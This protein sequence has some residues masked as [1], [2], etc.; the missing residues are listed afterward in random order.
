MVE[1]WLKRLEPFVALDRDALTTLARHSRVVRIAAG[2]RIRNRQVLQRRIDAR[3]GDGGRADDRLC[4][5]IDGRVRL[6]VPADRSQR[7]VNAHDDVARRPLFARGGADASA[8][9]LEAC[10]VLWVDADPVAFLFD[11]ARLQLGISVRWLP[12]DS[13]PTGW[14]ERFVS[15]GL[16]TS[17]PALLARLFAALRRSAFED[18]QAVIEEGAPG[19][20]FFVVAQGRVEIRSRAG[21][22]TVLE[23]GAGFGE[24]AIFHGGP[25]NATARMLG[26]GRLMRLDATSFRTLLLPAAVHWRERDMIDPDIPIIDLDASRIRHADPRALF[27]RMTRDARCAIAGGTHNARAHWTW[28]A[29]RAG[30]DTVAIED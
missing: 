26:G 6:E 7:I 5:L 25:R 28:L 3:A 27:A 10:R 4:Y 17:E 21:V 14:A 29:V 16:V 22:H 11:D 9:T 13:S 24:D 20:E 8:V 30:L 18:R 23:E 2:R 19:D 1:Q 12:D 15:R